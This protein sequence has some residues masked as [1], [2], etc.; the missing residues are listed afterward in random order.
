[1][2]RTTEAR[3][4]STSSEAQPLPETVQLDEQGLHDIFQRYYA[5]L[6]LFA[7]QFTDDREQAADLT[8]EAFIKLWE[9]R[10]NFSYLHQVRSFLY[11][12]VRNR[13]LNELEHRRVVEEYAANYQ[14][15]ASEVFFEETL[16]E[17]E[18][19]RILTEAIDSLP[20]R[21]R[22]VMRLALRGKKNAE[23]AEQ[24]E[25]SI[26]NV[27]SLRQQAYKRLRFLLKD[28]YYSLLLFIL[29]LPH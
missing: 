26:E 1:M 21:M 18:T 20:T 2:T 25:C 24:L 23:I 9:L 22:E 3:L 15:K 11:L 16:I 6:C 27:R 17:Q 19:Y 10:T 7:Y 5:P 29:Q 13:A 14:L 4:T 28:Y 12:T 8:Q